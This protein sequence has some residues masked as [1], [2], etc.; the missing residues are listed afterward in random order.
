M[1]SNNYEFHE[2]LDAADISVWENEGGSP[3]RGNMNHHYGRRIEP[4]GSWTIYQVFTGVPAGTGS[5]SM[6]GLSEREATATMMVLNA[7][8][9]ERRKA[10]TGA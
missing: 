10:A 2:T 7:R 1:N 5:R 4:N 8:H 9:V 6:T 3:D